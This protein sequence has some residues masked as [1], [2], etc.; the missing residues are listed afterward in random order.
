MGSGPTQLADF[1]AGSLAGNNVPQHLRVSKTEKPRW[2]G[3]FTWVGAAIY[4]LLRL[5]VS[6]GMVP[7]LTTDFPAV[8][9]SVWTLA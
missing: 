5:I 1:T 7:N 6:D 8:N 9:F 4:N 2:A 3:L